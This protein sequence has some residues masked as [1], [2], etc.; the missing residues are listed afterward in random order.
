[1]PAAYRQ[2]DIRTTFMQRLPGV[3]TR[4]QAYMPIYPLALV[5]MAMIALSV[6]LQ[7]AMLWHHLR[8]PAGG[9]VR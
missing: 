7:G 8:H 1:M 9:A 3:T 4:H 2:W 5:M 6:V